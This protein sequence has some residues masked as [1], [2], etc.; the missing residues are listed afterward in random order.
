MKSI[1]F[2]KKSFT[3][4]VRIKYNDL[5][6]LNKKR[7]F[8]PIFKKIE[9]AYGPDGIGAIVIEQVYHHFETKKICLAQTQKIVNMP[10]VYLE[11]YERPDVNYTLGYSH[12]K[13]KF[14]NEPDHKK[15]SYYAVLQNY[16]DNAA[17]KPIELD[18]KWP[19]EYAPQLPG[20]FYALGNQIR[21]VGLLLFDAIDAY[22]KRQN[23]KYNVNCK[24]L[25]KQS[26]FNV[27]R[28][29][30]YFPPSEEEVKSGS[31][32]SNWCGWHNDHGLLTGLT[33][34]MYFHQYGNHLEE[35]VFKDTGLY[36]QSRKGELIK[37]SYKQDDLAFQI[38][39]VYQI[40]SG[41]RLLATPH[42]VKI[43][44][45]APCW[46]N[47]STFALFMQPNK[48]I[49]LELPEGDSLSD[50]KTEDIYNVPK[51]QNRYNKQ[52]MTFE[53]FDK[54]TQEAYYKYNY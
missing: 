17:N 27:G 38:G 41:N 49:K 30:H 31:Y 24:E 18:N 10:K 53:E 15:A 5:I 43:G 12:G 11:K 26:N 47:R 20:A 16:Y 28:L 48:D 45:D 21:E 23:P 29:L 6:H 42:M 36:A 51:L 14:L 50:I 1:N 34:A 19:R 3:E 22:I 9:K 32:E 7:D 8:T 4:V 13:E 46:A 52:G 2:S 40:L 44:N 39:E 35:P 37:V 33:S 54:N 25:I